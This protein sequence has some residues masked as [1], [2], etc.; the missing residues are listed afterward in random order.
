MGSI[1]IA[2]IYVA[3]ISLG[4]P[5]SLL[6]SAWPVMHVD[7]G[8]SLSSAGIIT[9]IISV[10]T[11]FSALMTDKVVKRL[12]TG[13]TTA[14]SILLTACAMLAFSFSASLWQLCIFAIPYGLGAGA[15]DTCLNDYVAT[16]LSSKHMNWLHCCWGI[17]ATISP[18]IMGYCL[19]GGNSWHGGYRIVSVIQFFIAFFIFLSIPLWSKKKQNDAA[20]EPEESVA[21]PLLQTIRIRGTLLLF[22]SGLLYFALEQMPM[23][24]A[25]TYFSE[26]FSMDA[27]DAAFF[28]SLFYIGITVSRAVCG[29]FS[30]K[31]GDKKLIR[32]GVIT[33][34][35]SAFL[36]MLPF[37]S[38]I[39]ALIGFILVGI[40]CGP[41]CP[42]MIHA[43]PD[44]FDKKYSCSIIGTQ[45]SFSYLGMTFT[46][47]LSGKLLECTT[48]KILPVC[49]VVL[50]VMILT[51]T[52][53]LNQNV[54]RRKQIVK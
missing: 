46:P 32:A 2:I 44:N 20:E 47:I 30:D 49:I 52:E 29:F 45:M 22:F 23:V 54:V 9:M 48:I 19:T 24:W 33:A 36:I 42:C 28:A 7:L 13:T 8:T 6:G 53:L 4:L 40:G 21:L 3:F 26:V 1:F 50:A 15:I 41:V 17:G 12:G 11:I 16:H 14:V 5:D 38:H 51:L 18:Y 43:I 35:A 37:E 31:I 39:L 10:C 34:A 25:S 27:D